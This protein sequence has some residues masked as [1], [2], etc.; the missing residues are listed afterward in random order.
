VDDASD[1]VSGIAPP[2]QD[3][4]SLAIE[5]PLGKDVLLLTALDGVEEVSRGFV[6]TIEMLTRAPDSD[7]RSLLGKPVTLWLRNNS[8]P[9]RR[10]LHG[11]IRHLARIAVDP[12]GY[13]LWRAEVAPWLWFLSHSVDCRIYQDVSVPEILRSVFDEHG[14]TDYVIRLHGQYP[15]LTYCVQYRET[16]LAFVSRLMEHVG[17]FYA[18]EHYS[19]RHLLVLSDYSTHAKFTTPQDVTFNLNARLAEIQE[20][21]HSYTFRAGNWALCD[22]DFEFPTKNLHTREATVLD[23]D[24]MKRFEIFDYPGHYLERDKGADLTRL[25]VEQEEAQHHRVVGAG[26][27]AG[28]D[29]GKRFI[30]T[31]DRGDRAT[32]PEAYFLT[33]VRHSA[34]ETHYFANVQESETYSNRFKAIPAETP[35]RPE[36][37]TRKPVVEGLQTATVVGPSGENIHT[38]QYG[39]VRVLFHWDR[40][41]KRDEHAS[42]WIRVSQAA[43]GAHWGGIAIPHVGHEVIV[44]FLEGDPDRPIVAGSVHN[45][46][47]MPPVVLPRDKNKT[48]LRDHGDNKIVM[49]GKAGRQHM[50]LVSP[51]SLNMFAIR[52]GAKALSADVPFLSR[53]GKINDDV[54][55]F[56]DTDSLNEL[57]VILKALDDPSFPFTDTNKPGSTLTPA[58]G[59]AQP[60]AVTVITQN[61]VDDNAATCDINS[62]SEGNINGLSLRNTNAWVWGNSNTWVKQNSNSKVIGNVSSEVDGDVGSSIQGS[63]TAFIE[64]DSTTNVTGNNN[65]KVF[66]NNTQVILGSNDSL[67]VGLNTGML[68][69]ATF[70]LACPLSVQLFIG[71][72]SQ[73]TIGLAQQYASMNIQKF[74]FNMQHNDLNVSWDDFKVETADAKISN[75]NAFMAAHST[76]FLFT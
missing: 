9:E 60:N 22:Y 36:R 6:Y 49:H 63:S 5:T 35:F 3:G 46:T 39:R 15:K 31:P 62:M 57:K 48:I 13:W 64:S 40:R 68:V 70:T 51:R 75:Y 74:D 14:L 8:E 72:N 28:F 44:A 69:G 29:P 4:H 1:L 67:V 61:T 50:A 12:N 52:N 23:I 2:T 71:F 32:K 24:P 25:R 58:A 19:D 26:R 11:H 73:L 47:N 38:D 37:L 33:E 65:L 45:G 30:L 17:I 10:P 56:M 59:T 16:A 7:V 42:C 21:E 34:R 54:D 18:F 20:F 53:D 27:V 66:G 76:I 43:A 55:G 41:G